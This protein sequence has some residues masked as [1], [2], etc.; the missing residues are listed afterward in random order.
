LEFSFKEKMKKSENLI[1]ISA[2]NI[3]E[4]GMLSI[5][6][7]VFFWASKKTDYQFVFIVNSK[8]L[9]TEQS[10][11]HIEFIEIPASKKNWLNRVF[12]EYAYFYFVSLKIKPT[13][14]F[15]LHDITPN[16]HAPIRAVYC[17][18]PA[19]FLRTSFKDLFVDWKVFLFSKFYRYLYRINIKKNTFVCVQQH[20]IGNEFSRMFGIENL[21]ITP[22]E[23][24]RKVLLTGIKPEKLRKKDINK[25]TF[26]FPSFP[27]NFK[28]FE[29]ICAAVESMDHHLNFEVLLTIDGSEN[30][31]S[32]SIHKKWKQESRLKFIG[33]QPQVKLFEIYEIADALIFPSKLETWG[34]PLSEFSLTNKP[35]FA[36]DLVHCHETLSD[37]GKACFFDPDDADQLALLLALFIEENK[38]IPHKMSITKKYDE[39][40]GWEQVFSFLLNHHIT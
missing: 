19:C 10:H 27:R 15:S 24:T 32:A 35:I 29:I 14:W 31:Y 18:N 8:K 6:E 5:L 16:V 39:K 38:F 2:P 23:Q 21:L 28:N 25:V 20:W 1:V 36:A 4:S 9:L 30:N 3:I 17:H 37:Y 33:I 26:V 40:H 34:L 13:L 12:F 11:S 22:P 7:S